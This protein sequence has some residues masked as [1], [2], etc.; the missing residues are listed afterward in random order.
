MFKMK[1]LSNI[2]FRRELERLLLDLGLSGIE[3]SW[4]AEYD[5]YLQFTEWFGSVVM[6]LER[7]EGGNPNLLFSR[8]EISFD[9]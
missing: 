9:R 6:M 7:D 4:E 8:Q 5:R 2:E 3:M 1:P